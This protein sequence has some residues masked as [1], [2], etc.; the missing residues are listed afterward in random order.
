[1]AAWADENNKAQQRN[2]GSTITHQ[3]QKN[4]SQNKSHKNSE[5]VNTSKLHFEFSLLEIFIVAD[6]IPQIL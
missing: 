5:T 3:P 6:L 4:T 2:K 1:M